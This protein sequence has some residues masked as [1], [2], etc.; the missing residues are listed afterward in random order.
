[1]SASQRSDAQ[2]DPCQVDASVPVAVA[3]GAKAAASAPTSASTTLERAG[4][5]DCG[6][7]AGRFGAFR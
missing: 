1:M 6:L 7:A 5:A 4:R 2:G 3:G